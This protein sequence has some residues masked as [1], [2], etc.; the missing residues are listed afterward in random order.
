MDLSGDVGFMV[1][2]VTGGQVLFEQFG[3]FCQL[4]DG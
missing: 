2:M 1:D 4:L 3:F